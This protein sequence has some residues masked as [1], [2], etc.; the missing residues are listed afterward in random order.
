MEYSF[1][2]KENA[3]EVKEALVGTNSEVELFQYEFG[4]GRKSEE[5]DWTLRIINES[6]EA[7]KIVKHV[8]YMQK[9]KRLSDFFGKQDYKFLNL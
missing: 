8:M 1:T 4:D 3:L 7:E 5:T 6:K 9:S 2:K